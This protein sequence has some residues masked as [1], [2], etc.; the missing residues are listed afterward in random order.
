MKKIMKT[1]SIILASVFFV[2]VV[3]IGILMAT[4]N[5]NDLKGP[6]IGQIES[7]SDFKIIRMG[8]IAWRF[9]PS[10]GISVHDLVLAKPLSSDQSILSSLKEVNIKIKLQPL[11]HRSFEFSEIIL[12]DAK[13]EFE[14]KDKRMTNC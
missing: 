5:P 8:N 13:M 1:F 7:N 6:I 11:L 10:F 9:F 14:K 2:V 12:S 4:L 3:G